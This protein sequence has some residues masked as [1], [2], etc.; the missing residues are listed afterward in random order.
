MPWKAPPNSDCLGLR[1]F[2]DDWGIP[3]LVYPR[4]RVELL[5]E[6][7]P[8]IIGRQEAVSK[9]GLEHIHSNLA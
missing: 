8:V 2:A 9:L 3:Q 6:H 4:A 1:P 7:D 5:L